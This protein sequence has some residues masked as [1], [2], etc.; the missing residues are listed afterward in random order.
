MASTRATTGRVVLRSGPWTG[1]RNT[2]EPF[3]D[4]PNLLIDAKNG[5][6]VDPANGSGFFQRPGFTLRNMGNAVHTDTSAFKGQGVYSHPMLDGTTINFL[7]FGGHLYRVNDGLSSFTDVT[8]VGVTI[9][10]DV[11]TRVYF[12]SLLG[13]MMVTDGVNRPWI[14]SDLTA[15]P[16]TGTYID[17]DSAGVSWSVYGKPAL[18]G[19]AVFVIL[20]KVNGVSRRTD[21]AWCQP[22]QLSVGW[23]QTNYDNNWTLETASSSVLFAISGTNT[24]LYYWRELSIGTA[25][26][27]VGPDLQST[28][29]EDAI[30][31]NV[32][33]QATQTVQ[34]FGTGFFFCD[35]AGRPWRLEPG[36]APQAIWYQFRAVVDTAAQAYPTVTAA[37]AT[38]VIE[39]TL[40]KWIVGI[41]SPNPAVNA[42]VTKLHVFDANSGIYEGWWEIGPGVAI[43]C[44]GTFV[45][46]AGRVT[47]VVLGSKLEAPATSGYVW[48]FNS[49]ASI[50]QTLVEEDLSTILTTENG[51]Y[52]TTEGQT[53]IWKDDGVRPDVYAISGRLGYADDTTYR[54][55]QATI[56]TGT[57]AM[58]KLSIQ[59]SATSNT[60]Q[61]Y[62]EPSASHDETYRLVAGC[63]AFGRGPQLT[64]APQDADAQ[65]ALYS[66]SLVAVAQ[67]A[68]WQ[69][70]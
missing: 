19:N 52:L 5:Y 4:P 61:G 45:D 58:V 22:G 50:P 18:Y 43:D 21:L 26:G 20:N 48:S 44:I 69:D 3:D 66:A 12:A 28:A 46:A 37:V 68:R 56:V 41:W 35:A 24:A 29:T 15:T 70:A 36:A 55:D 25:T 16:V 13:D 54:V 39:P 10:G 49:L 40:N 65:W 6:M 63:N 27:T 34:Q 42:S 14:A 51:I 9:D 32:G 8:P 31:F 2:Q 64:M 67:Q 7:V 57:D 33:A 38:S 30:G 1:V 62:P 59:S 23:Q 11:N 47:V 17:Y 60:V 53:A